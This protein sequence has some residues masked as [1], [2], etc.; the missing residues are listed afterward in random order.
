RSVFAANLG[1]PMRDS[2]SGQNL[3][4]ADFT[5]F[6]TPGTYT[7]VI[8]SVGRSPAFRIADDVYSSL[9]SDALN[10]YEQLAVLAPSAWQTAPAKERE[11]GKT[12]D[13]SGGWPDAGDYGRYMPSAAS[14]MGTLLLLDDV[15]P[16]HATPAQLEV[17]K[18]ELDWMLKMQRS[19]GAVYHKVTPLKFG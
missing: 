11:T 13:I 5:G 8:P 15:F 4:R 2:D 19:D 12:M 6:T 17:Y 16:Q 1:D 10:S 18:R 7:L 14:A 3:R 9:Y